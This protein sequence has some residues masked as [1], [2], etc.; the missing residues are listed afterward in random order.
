MSD[1]IDDPDERW[2]RTFHP[3]EWQRKYLDDLVPG[4]GALLD[5]A[6]VAA[7]TNAQLAIDAGV[8]AA[9]DGQLEDPQCEHQERCAFPATTQVRCRH[10]GRLVGLLCGSHLEQTKAMQVVH[11][12][13]GRTNKPDLLLLFRTIFTRRSTS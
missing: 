5:P 8:L 7:M 4:A 2:R 12:P 9:L 10:S 3:E 11:C 6:V 13:C 1:L